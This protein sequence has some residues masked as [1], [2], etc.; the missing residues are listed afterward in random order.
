MFVVRPRTTTN[1]LIPPPHPSCE[2][3]ELCP[4]QAC[5]PCQ[6]QAFIMPGTSMYMYH[7]RGSNK[8]IT[9]NDIPRNNCVC[10]FVRMCV[11]VP[12]FYT[13]MG[14]N[15][16]VCSVFLCVCVTYFYS[17]MGQN[18]CV[19]SVFPSVCLPYFYTY[20]GQNAAKLRGAIV[21]AHVRQV[22]H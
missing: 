2:S 8:T 9:A 11:C 4:V 20:M 17:Y 7:V 6:V 16:C 12:Y 14:Q 10:P 19:C 1:S 22:D 21:Y 15:V 13:S 18:A 5:A 3:A